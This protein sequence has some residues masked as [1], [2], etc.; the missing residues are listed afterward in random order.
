M[1][2]EKPGCFVGFIEP[3]KDATIVEFQEL[4]LTASI[5]SGPLSALCVCCGMGWY[6]QL[7]YMFMCVVYTSV[8]QRPKEDIRCSTLWLSFLFL[9]SGSLTEPGTMAT[10]GY[11]Y[12]CSHALVFI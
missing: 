10:W 7:L 2:L 12:M 9:W 8:V 4:P 1:L 11:M 5:P 6:I 3:A